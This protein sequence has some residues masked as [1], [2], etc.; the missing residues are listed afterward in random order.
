MRSLRRTARL[1][2]AMAGAMVIVASCGGRGTSEP[3]TAPTS[4][5]ATTTMAPA[6]TTA[7]PTTTS[8]AAVTT[9]GPATTRSPVEA[10]L[11]LYAGAWSGTWT[12]TTFGSTGEVAAILEIVDD[13]RLALTVDLGGAVFGQEDP[14]EEQWILAFTDLLAPVTLQSSTFGEMTLILSGEG[15]RLT[16]ADVPAPG[17]ASFQLDARFEP[18]PAIVGTYLVGFDDG[19]IAEGTVALQRTG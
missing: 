5:A 9:T 8:T 17:I 10:F 11:D 2:L 15:A 19:S 1:A 16:A 6:P 18:D 7:A 14:P 4:A 13:G 3:T 12:N